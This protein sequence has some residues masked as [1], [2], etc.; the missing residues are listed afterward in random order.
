M[1]SLNVFGKCK[2]NLLRKWIMSMISSYGQEK[3]VFCGDFNSPEPLL[4]HLYRLNDSTQTTFLRSTSKP[5]TLDF[6]FTSFQCNSSFKAFFYPSVSDHKVLEVK[7]IINN[8]V[9]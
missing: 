3:F 8:F 7:I 9:S 4:P 1:P 6:I 5:S 2:R